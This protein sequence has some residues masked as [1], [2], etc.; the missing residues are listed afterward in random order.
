MSP[1]KIREIIEYDAL[2]G[3]LRRCGVSARKLDDVME[4]LVV[5]IAIRPEALQKEEKSGWSRIMVRS[6]SRVS[7]MRNWI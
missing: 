6:P 5:S 7:V 2:K 1:P 4:G 3:K